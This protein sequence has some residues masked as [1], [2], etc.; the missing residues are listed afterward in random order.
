VNSFR[1]RIAGFKYAQIKKLGRRLK[2]A[3]TTTDI[4]HRGHTMSVNDVN[5]YDRYLTNAALMRLGDA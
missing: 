5:I 1:Y 3:R 2:V 4:H